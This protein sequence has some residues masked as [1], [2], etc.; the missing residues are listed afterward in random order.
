MN[1][2]AQRYGKLCINISSSKRVPRRHT[3]ATN[4]NPVPPKCQC[5]NVPPL[6][7]PVDHRKWRNIIMAVESKHSFFGI[8]RPSV[9]T[10]SM[11][12]ARYC[13]TSPVA[14]HSARH[15]VYFRTVPATVW[16]VAVS[17]P[18][19]VAIP[20]TT[21]T[22]KSFSRSSFKAIYCPSAIRHLSASNRSAKV[23]QQLQSLY[24]A[25]HRLC[26]CATVIYTSIA[27]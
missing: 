15:A 27:E 4:I 11:P 7:T 14:C 3:L 13:G 22:C 10:H 23:P 16:S 12:D 26:S 1:T 18:V 20:C 17:R 6:C 21:L 9:H 8:T 19:D 5:W 25:A 2:S 24:R